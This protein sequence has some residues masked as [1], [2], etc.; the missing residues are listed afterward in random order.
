MKLFSFPDGKL[1]DK[2]IV[3]KEK[4]SGKITTKE[5]TSISR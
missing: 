2:Q 1:G 3:G 5:A 4:V